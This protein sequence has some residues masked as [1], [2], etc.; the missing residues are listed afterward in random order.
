MKEDKIV[1]TFVHGTFAK[2]AKWTQKK[3]LLANR[4]RENFGENI[5]IQSFKWSGKNSQKARLEAAEKLNKELS[6]DVN[7][8]RLHF[9]I[10][11]S[12]AGNIILQALKDFKLEKNVKGAICLNTPFLIF[13]ERKFQYQAFLGMFF[14]MLCWLVGFLIL[15]L[16]NNFQTHIVFDLSLLFLLPALIIIFLNHFGN[17]ILRLSIP[18][19]KENKGEPTQEYLLRRWNIDNVY[20][21]TLIVR[22]TSDEASI[23]ISMAQ[24]ISWFLNC[25]WIL[26]SSPYNAYLRLRNWYQN[27]LSRL[28]VIFAPS[29]IAL[30]F[31][32]MILYIRITPNLL[33]QS[34]IEWVINLTGLKYQSAV[35]VIILSGPFLFLLSMVIISLCF[36]LLYMFIHLLTFGLDVAITSP[37]F[38]VSTETTPQ[39]EWQTCLINSSDSHKKWKLNHSNIYEND[40]VIQKIINWIKHELNKIENITD[41]K[42]PAK[43]RVCIPNQ[44]K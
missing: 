7:E 44:K 16:R 3:S 33:S 28:K 39:G 32:L 8:K 37:L 30:S 13:R 5:Q 1:F 24:L 41:T 38:K 31:V 20:H 11:H 14:V 35:A 17:L 26:F 2:N 43:A 4:L 15:Y 42:D 25:S 21:P 40:E 19:L 34:W 27:M 23:G 10:G 12:H 9:V 6:E 18:L 36:L 29:V 22:V